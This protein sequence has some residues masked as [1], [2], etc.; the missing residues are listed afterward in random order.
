MVQ[1]RIVGKAPDIAKGV[2]DT[3]VWNLYYID[4]IYAAFLLCL[5]R[6]IISMKEDS[7]TTMLDVWSAP[8]L[9]VGD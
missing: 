9:A 3:L 7:P 6:N 2:Y 4:R 5:L 1:A 8:K